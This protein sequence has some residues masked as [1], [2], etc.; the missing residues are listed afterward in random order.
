MYTH[1]LQDLIMQ[2]SLTWVIS[3][4]FN[5]VLTLVKFAG[6]SPYAR[7]LNHDCLKNSTNDIQFP[8]HLQKSK[9]YALKSMLWEETIPN[10]N[11]IKYYLSLEWFN[12]LIRLICIRLREILYLLHRSFHFT[13]MWQILYL[14]HWNLIIW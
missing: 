12:G 7:L 10:M 3:L 9:A 4:V 1:I 14:L 5:K 13:W 2:Y 11:L 8:K 6:L